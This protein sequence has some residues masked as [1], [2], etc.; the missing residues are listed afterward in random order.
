MVELPAELVSLKVILPGCIRFDIVMVEPPAVPELLKVRLVSTRSICAVLAVLVL[1]K[2][3]VPKVAALAV[4]VALPA[5]LESLNVMVAPV[6][7]VLK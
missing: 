3:M 4:K 1:L 7:V 6:P 2:V 5:E